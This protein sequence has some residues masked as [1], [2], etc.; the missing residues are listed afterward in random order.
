MVICQPVANP[1]V[2]AQILG[3]QGFL[4]SV[5]FFL[6][7]CPVSDVKKKCTP[8]QKRRHA[9]VKERRRERRKEKRNSIYRAKCKKRNDDKMEEIRKEHEDALKT[10]PICFEEYSDSVRKCTLPCNSEHHFC[11]VCMFHYFF[12]SSFLTLFYFL[13]FQP[14]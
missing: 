12:I 3:K 13:H 11:Y 9:R 1:Y 7:M 5:L 8:G 2:F 6:D 14:L 10:C 4:Y